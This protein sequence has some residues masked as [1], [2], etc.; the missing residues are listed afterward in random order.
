MHL[1]E[2]RDAP[3]HDNKSVKGPRER[4]ILKRE[5]CEILYKLKEEKLVRGKILGINL[6]GSSSR[7]GTSK[8]T[9]TRHGPS[10]S[11]GKEKWCIQVRPDMTQV[12][13]VKQPKAPRRE[14][15]S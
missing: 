10:Q 7:G 1:G 14:S 4:V 13:A 9:T 12:M 3:S 6:K 5:K 11:Y 2:A 15:K 8:K